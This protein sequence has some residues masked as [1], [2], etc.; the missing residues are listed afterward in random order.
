M[1]PQQQWAYTGTLTGCCGDFWQSPGVAKGTSFGP[2]EEAVWGAWAPAAGG[3]WGPP[4][5]SEAGWAPGTAGWSG[6]GPH[7]EAAWGSFAPYAGGLW[8]PPAQFFGFGPYGEA[9]WGYGLPYQTA[10]LAPSLGNGGW[11]GPSTFGWP[12]HQPAPAPFPY[13]S[14]VPNASWQAGGWENATSGNQVLEESLEE[15][16]QSAF[17]RLGGTPVAALGAVQRLVSLLRQCEAITPK[18]IKRLIRRWVSEHGSEEERDICEPK[19]G[20]RKR[21][22]NDVRDMFDPLAYQSGS[23][24]LPA[25]SSPIVLEGMDKGH[26]LHCRPCGDAGAVGLRCYWAT[27]RRCLTHGWVPAMT[28]PVKARVRPRGKDGNPNHATVSAYPVTAAKKVRDLRATGVT[29]RVDPGDNKPNSVVSPFTMVIKNSDVIKAHALVDVSVRDQC[30]LDRANAILAS[31][32]MPAV[33]LRLCNDLTYSGV[34][35]VCV[36][37]YFSYPSIQDAVRHVRHLYHLAKGDVERYYHN[38]SVAE[39]CWPMFRFLYEEE[40]NE[41][42]RVCMGLSP[43]AYY[44]SGFSAEFRAWFDA[45]EIPTAHMMDDWLTSAETY[46]GARERMAT[47]K[48]WIESTGMKMQV[49]KDDIGQRIVFCGILIDTVSMTIS[50]APEQARGVLLILRAMQRKWASPLGPQPSISEVRSVT[51]ILTWYGGVLQSGPSRTRSWWIY[52]THHRNLFPEAAL[53]LQR[54]TE[55]WCQILESWASGTNSCREYPILSTARLL[56]DEGLIEVVVSDAAGVDGLGYFHGPL[57]TPEDEMRYHSSQWS[58]S[59]TFVHSHNGELRVLLHYLQRTEERNKIIVWVS[60][61]LAGVWSVLRGRSVKDVSMQTLREIFELADVKRLHLLALWVPRET[62]RFA[63]FLS[64]LS[65]TLRRS[66]VEGRVGDLA[67][68]GDKAVSHEGGTG[69]GRVLYEAREVEAI[70]SEALRGA[71]RETQYSALPSRVR[72]NVDVHSQVLQRQRAVGKVDSQRQ[73]GAEDA[74]REAGSGLVVGHGPAEVGRGDEGNGVPRHGA[75]EARQASS[76]AGHHEDAGGPRPQPVVGANVPRD[77]GRKPSRPSAIRRA[78][79]RVALQGSGAGPGERRV[80]FEFEAV[81]EEPEGRRGGHT[82]GSDSRGAQRGGS[83]GPVD[84]A[85]RDQWSARCA[86]IPGGNERGSSQPRQ[87][88]LDGLVPTSDPSSRHKGGAGARL[89]RPLPAGGRS[90]GFVR[91]KGAL[92]HRQ[93]GGALGK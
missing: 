48:M 58:D 63:D 28:G 10:W 15:P 12:Y 88:D 33:K 7:G 54:D 60:D 47:I 4:E 56:D 74:A 22:G 81:K 87:A 79:K 9:V 72:H 93:E 73:V 80:R 92:S 45:L 44:C 90:H 52:S 91:G 36:K 16:E 66:E 11:A 67:A 69:A 59:H 65:A 53:Q 24:L 68:D 19:S 34:N 82:S 27:M 40:L 84:R 86:D 20:V 13:F 78:L 6:V 8:S 76:E 35:A 75:D 85:P 43:S 71:V 18:E 1:S 55:W 42:M 23:S 21:D 57:N 41:M 77:G 5:Q 3:P 2:H 49:E 25:G 14:E 51:G 38:F 83:S 37:F 64:H 29:R 17:R 89:S 70:T 30:T 50:I 46:E 61:C 26:F 39:E 31:M 62:N 32:G